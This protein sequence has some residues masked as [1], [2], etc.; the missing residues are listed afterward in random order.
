MRVPEL[1]VPVLAD[2]DRRRC[3]FFVVVFDWG[4]RYEP[5]AVGGYVEV[6]G[7][8]TDL[9]LVTRVVALVDS[10]V[11]KDQ[12]ISILLGERFVLTFQER[13]SNVFNPVLK[14]LHN[15]KGRIRQL[16]ADYLACALLDAVIDG[17][18]PVVEA[19]GER[20][21]ELEEAAL[22][23]LTKRTL[24]ET[25][26]IR[27]TLLWLRR[28][29]RPQREAISSLM[30]DES[31][32]VTENVQPFLRDARDHCAQIAEVVE[33]YRELVNE[34]SNTYLTV[35]SNRTNEVRKVLTIMAS[36]FIPLT[37]MAGFYS[38]NFEHMP[39]LQLRYAYPVL[40]VAMLVV[41]AA[42][43][44]FFYRRGWLRSGDD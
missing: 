29:L 14:R 30:R 1:F 43:V 3:G 26:D 22:E 25:N 20:L 39:E 28:I 4:D 10:A 11:S 7:T 24:S 23:R 16:G 41:A 9:L 21:E 18:Y 32:L 37:F 33:S 34:I 31:S 17:Y 44:Y 40:W 15:A 35:V 12:Q 36:I 38:M 2:P 19:L 27:K 6:R 13:P 42:M 5:L 8:G